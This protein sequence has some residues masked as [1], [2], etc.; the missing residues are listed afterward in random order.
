MRVMCWAFA[1]ISCVGLI[2]C[3]IDDKFEGCG[4][5][6]DALAAEGL[7]PSAGAS[8]DLAG[9]TMALP[10]NY[11]Y[12][13]RGDVLELFEAPGVH[14]DSGDWGVL[15]KGFMMLQ[16]HKETV[17]VDP[18]RYFPDTHRGRGRE[19]ISLGV[20]PF[21]YS[22]A[23]NALNWDVRAYFSNV[24]NPHVIF[25]YLRTELPIGGQRIGLSAHYFPGDPAHGVSAIV[26]TIDKAIRD[27]SRATR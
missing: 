24:H 2:S 23:H 9:L 20:G 13:T 3:G 18:F 10:Q 15:Q 5:D 7:A 12:R 27:A 17:P 19:Q 25:M 14:C 22:F 21:E 4:A 6:A 16:V 8:F 26:A 11:M 1:L